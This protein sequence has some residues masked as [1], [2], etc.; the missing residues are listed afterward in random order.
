MQVL[1]VTGGLDWVDQ[2]LGFDELITVS[3]QIV[4]LRHDTPPR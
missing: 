1:V 2:L 3:L 4:G